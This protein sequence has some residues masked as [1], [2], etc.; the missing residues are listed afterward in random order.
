MP[1]PTSLLTAIS[2]LEASSA[3]RVV[4]SSDRKRVVEGKRGDFGGCRIIKKK[5][6]ITDIGDGYLKRR[7]KGIKAVRSRIMEKYI[8]NLSRGLGV[9]MFMSA[10]CEAAAYGYCSVYVTH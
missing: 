4:S 2:V 7:K 8:L 10:L 9:Q 6:K 5:K 3:A 1:R